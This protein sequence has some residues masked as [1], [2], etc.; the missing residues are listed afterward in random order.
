VNGIALIF[1]ARCDA[2]AG[3]LAAL[4]RWPKYALHQMIITG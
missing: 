2:G 3:R 4:E 1:A